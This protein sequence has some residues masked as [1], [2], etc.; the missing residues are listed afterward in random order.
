MSAVLY[1][2]L[3]RAHGLTAALA[4]ALLLHPVLAWRRP[5]GRY[6]L[7]TAWL[8]AGLLTAVF[9]LGLWLYPSW[10]SHLKPALVAAADPLWLRF[11]T[12][13]HLGAFAAA[14]AVAGAIGL[15]ASARTPA[16]RPLASTLLLCAFA[17]GL[18]TACLGVWVGAHAHPGW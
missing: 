15:Q 12:K 14:L 6:L 11:E 18:T 1:A 13:E 9:W 7:L 16:L 3:A 2:L 10:R 4:L 8:G 5:L 17:C